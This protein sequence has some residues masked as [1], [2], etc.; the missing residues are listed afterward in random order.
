[1]T[2][3]SRLK[4]SARRSRSGGTAGFAPAS[5]SS[6]LMG[7]GMVDTRDRVNSSFAGCGGLTL[8]SATAA[9]GE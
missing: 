9:H 6:G 7:G 3:S 2:A 8:E 4:A 5:Q 1:M